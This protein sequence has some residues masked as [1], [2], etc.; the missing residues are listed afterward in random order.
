MRRRSGGNE[1][2]LPEMCQ[3][4]HFLGKTQMPVMNRVERTAQDADRNTDRSFV[5]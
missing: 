3:F 4:E 1:T 2:D 5:H